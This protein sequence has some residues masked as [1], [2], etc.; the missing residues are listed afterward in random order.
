MFEDIDPSLGFM[1]LPDTKWNRIDIGS[2][3]CLAIPVRRGIRTI[4]DLR[5][6]HLPLLINMRAKILAEMFT[7]Y[8]LGPND[9][10]MY[11]HYL[12]TDYHLHMHVV[13]ATWADP[14][15][16]LDLILSMSLLL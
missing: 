14:P 6:E 11:F 13:N 7:R 1:L 9:V 16:T 12:P 8:Q 15:G 4:R 3:Y 10:R 5:S 2:L